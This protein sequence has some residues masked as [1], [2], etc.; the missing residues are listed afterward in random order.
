MAVQ[1][2]LYW[3]TGNKDLRQYTD[4]NLIVLSYFLRK[5]Y[6]ALLDAGSDYAGE[7]KVSQ[8]THFISIGT[9]TNKYR[10]QG[11]GTEPDDADNT[12][13]AEPDTVFGTQNTGGSDVGYSYFQNMYHNT[14][15]STAATINASGSLYWSSPDL[16]IGPTAEADL[17]DTLVTDCITQMKTGDEVGS[18]RVSTT[19]PGSGTWSDKGTFFTDTKYG[20]TN[21]PANT[22]NQTTI[23]TYKLWLKT[24]NTTEP[25][26]PDNY[27]TW[28]DANNEIQLWATADYTAVSPLINEV[29]INVIA[30]RALTYNVAT[31]SAGTNRG[32]FYDKVWSTESASTAPVNLGIYTRYWTPTGTEVDQNGPYYFNCIGE[33]DPDN[34]P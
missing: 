16:K 3:D 5:R 26:S 10:T 17:R 31:A 24:A 9:A 28:D 30:R 34:L 32:I 33:R 25:S 15:F 11:S 14:A 4:A 21:L 1:R 18:Y 12:G 22:T 29:Y 8:P 7:V 23:N 27:I 19:D 6:A 2:P 13:G 20:S